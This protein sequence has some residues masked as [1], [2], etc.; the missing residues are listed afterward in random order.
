MAVSLQE[1]KEAQ[2]EPLVPSNASRQFESKR[3]ALEIEEAEAH[4]EP[5]IPLSEV[6]I[7]IIMRILD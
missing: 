7:R 2:L 3:E 4:I 5:L 6:R 1:E